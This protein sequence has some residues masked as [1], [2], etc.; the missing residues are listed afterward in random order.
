MKQAAMIVGLVVVCAAA[1]AS[2][3]TRN[4]R[5]LFKE[6]FGQSVEQALSTPDAQDDLELARTLVDAAETATDQPALLE[7][8]C[9]E[10]FTIAARHAA[11]V[12]T[13][14]RAMELLA[15]TIPDK[16]PAA[17]AKVLAMLQSAFSS[18][19]GQE[20]AKIGRI[21]IDRF[22]KA[23]DEAAADGEF[24][25]ALALYRRALPLALRI[26]SGDDE[27]IRQQME[28]TTHRHRVMTQVEGLKVRL[29]KN[30]NDAAAAKDL[31]RLLI[32][33][34]DSPGDAVYYASALA[35]ETSQTNVR[36]AAK[37]ME[38]LSADEKHSLGVWYE[39]QA[40]AASRFARP[41]V[42]ERA[43]ELLKSFL[44]GSSEK[45]IKTV[46]AQ[47][48]L[49]RASEALA[50]LQSLGEA[51]SASVK[52]IRFVGRPL[53]IQTEQAQAIEKPMEI[54]TDGGAG[55]GKFIWRPGTIGDRA[56]GGGGHVVIYIEI[57]R[58]ADVYV[59]GR[60][61]A[62][63][64]SNNSFYLAVA[65]GTTTSGNRSTWYL[66]NDARNWT[67]APYTSQRRGGN[68]FGRFGPPQDNN[69]DQPQTIKL[70]KGVNSIIITP[71]EHGAQL[72]ALYLSMTAERPR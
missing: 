72:D 59:W 2:E 10:A 60:V 12:D 56:E 61:K 25:A 49:K 63:D 46:Q 9:N 30:R 47:L 53:T 22:V 58:D 6:L 5:Q 35:D 66:P 43:V 52:P 7:V 70:V 15:K 71:R 8:I 48:V 4:P 40:A 41:V 14:M 27:T 50:A 17:D 51:P 28:R 32:V 34:L 16:K 1:A 54:G 39:G 57:S 37:P 23:G 24:T 19:Q 44:D 18:S 36:L 26:K 65:E 29:L 31:T 20:Q 42:L 3:D 11:G 13:A 64:E 38:D 67:W 33:E 69:G 68:R 45:D 21:L 55:G 62:P